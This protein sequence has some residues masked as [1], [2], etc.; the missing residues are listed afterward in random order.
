MCVCIKEY[1]IILKI[2]THIL[3]LIKILIFWVG[4]KCGHP[5]VT[6]GR[7]YTLKIKRAL[8]K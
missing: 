2:W 3:H 1:I 5:V 4:I 6:K 7:K 8:N